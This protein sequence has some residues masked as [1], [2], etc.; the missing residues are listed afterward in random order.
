METKHVEEKEAKSLLAEATTVNVATALKNYS[1]DQIKQLLLD[2]GNAGWIR[3]DPG[4]PADSEN[5]GG[6]CLW[7]STRSRRIQRGPMLCR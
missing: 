6:D 1:D 7:K 4:K 2:S 3:V 5:V